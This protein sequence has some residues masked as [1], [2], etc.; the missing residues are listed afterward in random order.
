MEYV[1]IH[2][3]VTA[4]PQSS[5][6]MIKRPLALNPNKRLA[7]VKNSNPDAVIGRPYKTELYLPAKLEKGVAVE[8]ISP[9]FG[10][11]NIEQPFGLSTKAFADVTVKP[12]KDGTTLVIKSRGLVPAS[13]KGVSTVHDFPIQIK[14]V[15][16][17]K[18]RT[19]INVKH[20]SNETSPLRVSG[21]KQEH[22]IHA[23]MAV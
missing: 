1:I 2:S 14:D 5:T 10:A 9:V 6:S 8:L 13:I 16:G 7:D 4:I 20:P 11:L 15:N 18:G 12:E 22:D 23:A 19:T 21:E 3:M 17:V